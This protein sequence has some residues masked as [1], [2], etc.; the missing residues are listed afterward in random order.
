MGILTAYRHLDPQNPA[1]VVARRLRSIVAPEEPMPAPEDPEPAPPPPDLDADRKL[2]VDTMQAKP[3]GLGPHIEALDAIDRV[4]AVN[5]NSSHT[6]L[7]FRR[8]LLYWLLDNPAKGPIVEVGTMYGGMTALFGYIGA[9]TGRH[10]FAIDINPDCLER[11]RA[12]CEEFGVE[13]YVTFVSG[14]L[15][16]FLDQQGR[17]LERAD[18]MFLDSSHDYNLTLIELRALHANGR[19]LPRALVLHDFNYRHASQAAWFDDCPGKNP[20][21]VDV[22]CRDFF[23]KEFRGPHF[24]KRCGAFSGDGTVTTPDNPG[25]AMGDYVDRYGSEGMMIFYP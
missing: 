18:L 9:V 2:A 15:M 5:G 3:G 1:R 23:S 21:A 10:C 6:T 4:N 20:I 19:V 22:A 17:T 8:E 11:S 24:F 7:R 13:P 12:T 14:D 16:R 25:A